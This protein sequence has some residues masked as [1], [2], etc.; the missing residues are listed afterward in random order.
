MNQQQSSEVNQSSGNN[1]PFWLDGQAKI[2]Y[3]R[4]RE[5]HSTQVLV[6]GGGI[7]GLTTAYLLLKLGKEVTVVEDGTIGSGESGRTTAHITCALDDRYYFIEETFGKETA[8]L[9]A[10]SH[11][12]AVN[13]IRNIIQIE[14]FDCNLKTVDGYLFPDPSDA[15]ENLDK[16]FEA[17][18]SAGIRTELVTGVPGLSNTL[19]AIKFPEQAQFHIMK[20]LKGLCDS[21]VKMGGTIFTDTRATD[22]TRHGA[23]GNGFKIDAQ[24]VVVATNSPVNDVLTMHTKQA[25]YRSYVI[26]AK[27]QKGK[28]PYALWW[29]TGNAHS[30]WVSQP[31]HYVR[32]EEFDAEYDLLICGGE[33]HK[34]G[35]ADEEHIPEQDRYFNLEQWARA[36]FP[37]IGE[38]AYYWSGQV[39][40]PVDSLG[41]M[42]R[43][44]GDDNIFIITGDS[45][46]GMT[47]TTIG[48]MIITDTI[49]GVKNPWE[50]IYSPSR[51]TFN[52]AKDFVREAANMASQYIDWLSPADLENAQQLQKGDGGIIQSGVSKIAVYRDEA[53][54]L[55][56][57]S[58]VCPHLG[59][60]VKW[61]KDEKSF[62][63]PC[64]GS[65]FDC[66][67]NVVNG[68]SKSNLK[69]LAQNKQT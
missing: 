64:H 9:A 28:L 52:T 21:I 63:C 40:E 2:T 50:E 31:Y 10:E 14:G 58:A 16:E 48:A 53:N 51:I 6:I 37:E 27:I 5:N 22:I 24:Y 18:R 42:G 39:M 4:L 23:K 12:A 43:N 19:R 69:P 11:T 13:M 1:K 60:I 46:N 47:H 33:D 7:A 61:N 54:E 44:P 41:F 59:C 55:H 65:R 26:A 35:Q 29:D 15:P 34:T 49:N 66:H 56:T 32:L 30:R 17:T 3:E 62:D 38:I 67:G 20:Y 68:P 25:A 36:N 57:Y 8:Q 45:G